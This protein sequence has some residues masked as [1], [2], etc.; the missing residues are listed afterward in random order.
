MANMKPPTTSDKVRFTADLIRHAPKATDW[1]VKRL[2]R[3]GETVGRRQTGME[4]EKSR[5]IREKVRT[6]CAQIDCTVFLATDPNTY[7][8]KLVAPDGT[9]IPVPTS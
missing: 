9:E 6:L 4:P 8:L 2:L 1:H 5:R 7:A 3:Y